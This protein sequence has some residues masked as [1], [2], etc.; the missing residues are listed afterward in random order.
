MRRALAL[1]LVAAGC[2][3]PPSAP[4]PDLARTVAV[5]PPANH[6]G[7]PLLV[8]G[9]S[10]FERWALRS[11]RVTV[12][13]VLA[14]EA[15]V[16]LLRRGFAV[17][18]ADVVTT[19]TGD[20]APESAAAAAALAARGHLPGLA[21]W[22][23]VRRWE[24]DAPVHPAFVIVALV[25]SLVDPASGRVVWTN[26]PP[27]A[28]VATPGEVE[29]GAAYVT[30]ARKAMAALLAPLGPALSR[31]WHRQGGEEGGEPQDGR[32]DRELA[33]DGA[34]E[35]RVAARDRRHVPE[36]ARGAEREQHRRESELCEQDAAVGAVDEEVEVRDVHAGTKDAGGEEHQ[37]GGG[38]EPT[39]A[40]CDGGGD[41]REERELEEAAEPCGRGRQMEAVG[42][43]GDRAVRAGVS[44]EAPGHE[45]ERRERGGAWRPGGEDGEARR[46]RRPQQTPAGGEHVDEE[47]PAADARDRV[48]A[49]DREA[50]LEREDDAQ[51]RRRAA[52]RPHTGGRRSRDQRR[53]A[54]PAGE[55]DRGGEVEP[56]EACKERR[57]GP[58]TVN[59]KRP[60]VGCVSTETTAQVTV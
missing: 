53:E 25:A 8:A 2:A 38:R 1:V 29:L 9:A 48:Q 24:P 46:A 51:Q 10:F 32:G 19:A 17:V 18:P 3:R 37:D 45:P 11:D 13:D 22:L 56:A 57:H 21:L 4:P 58:R 6:T 33:A 41:R 40:A 14:A 49:V 26:A 20:R 36:V 55:H 43:R 35:R 16:Q 59:V 15:R 31:R 28:P 5:L 60:S 7:D 23:E 39:D 34:S 12:P 54:E 27:P 50:E 47:R 52:Q 30:A 42:Q 44:L